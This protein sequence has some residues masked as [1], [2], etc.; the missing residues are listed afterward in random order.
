MLNRRIP[1]QGSYG[2]LLSETSGTV[3]GHIVEMQE[4]YLSIYLYICTERYF[5]RT[6]YYSP[7]KRE[8]RYHSLTP[9]LMICMQY[10]L[11]FVIHKGMTRRC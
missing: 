8:K 11:F 1:E 6:I 9:H 5:T 10:D 7:E 2:E 3:F 4:F